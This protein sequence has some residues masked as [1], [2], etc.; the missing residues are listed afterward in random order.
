M[1]FK[2]QDLKDYSSLNQ[3]YLV[4]KGIFFESFNHKEFKN[5]T[6]LN[7]NFLQENQSKSSKNVNKDCISKTH[8]TR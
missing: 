2:K 1:T 7:V 4:I 8:L 6:G 5:K 3:K